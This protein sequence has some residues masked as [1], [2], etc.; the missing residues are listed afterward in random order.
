MLPGRS[1]APC[2][3]L[4]FTNFGEPGMSDPN[5]PTQDPY[6]HGAQP[7]MGDPY[8][9]DPGAGLQYAGPGMVPKRPSSPI[10]LGI[11]GILYAIYLTACMAVG[12]AF[13]SSG[14][15]IL[16]W[17]QQSGGM[18]PEDR[19][20]LESQL[21]ITP[22]QLTQSIL[23]M[24]IGIVCWVGAIGSLMRKEVGRK[25]LLLFSVSFLLLGAAGL[26]IE[27]ARG[28]PSYH[29]QVQSTRGAPAMPVG[30]MVAI[31]M[32]CAAVFAIYPI[33]V[34]WFYTRDPV[35]RWFR[36]EEPAPPMPPPMYYNQ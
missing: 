16:D 14:G 22:W 25:A 21:Q 15:A 26:I 1:F 13:Q 33:C 9:G 11:I 31:G 23:F 27:A 34:L 3:M 17:F 35:K 7:P 30:L 28:F 5:Q 18:S 29:V 20:Q 2:G 4:A 10:V 12:L 24:V 36:N 19:A 32:M 8:Y 6:G